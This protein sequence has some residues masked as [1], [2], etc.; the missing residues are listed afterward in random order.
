MQLSASKI[1]NPIKNC[2]KELNR[3]F[4]KEDIQMTTEHMKDTQHHI[5]SEKHKSEPLWGTISHWSEW[6]LSKSLQTINAGESVDKEEPAYTDIWN[7]N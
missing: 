7:A 2:V 3:R 5:L 6:L 4:P 1:N